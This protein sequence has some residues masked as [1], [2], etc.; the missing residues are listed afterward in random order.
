M[1]CNHNDIFAEIAGRFSAESALKPCELKKKVGL[2]SKLSLNQRP[3]P[4]D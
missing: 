1:L 2:T 4:S 3:I